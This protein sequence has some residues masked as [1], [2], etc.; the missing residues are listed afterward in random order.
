FALFGAI[1]LFLAA[2]GIYGVL[3]CSVSQRVH[4]LGV[5]IALGAKRRHMV[6]LV[7]L[8]GLA[9]ALAG[10]GLG[11]VCALAASRFLEGELYDVSP[12]DLASFTAIPLLLLGVALAACWVPTRRAMDADPMEAIRSE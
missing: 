2:I 12:T 9:L 10:I 4:E 5:R 1:A 7:L 8:R 3:S 6:A 11:L